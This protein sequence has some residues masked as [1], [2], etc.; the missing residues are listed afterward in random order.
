M[1][2]IDELLA[3]LE[4]IPAEKIPAALSQLAA[5]QAKLAARLLQSGNGTH[6][7]TADRLLTAKEASPSIGVKPDWLYDHAEQLP[8][9]VRLPAAKAKG[10]GETKTHLRFSALGIQK[11]IRSRSGR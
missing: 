6:A 10:N 11:W 2:T 9:V 4:E 1:P 3:S 5:A 8:F 7:E